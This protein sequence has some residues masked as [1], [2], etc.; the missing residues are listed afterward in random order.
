PALH[1]IFLETELANG[2]TDSGFYSRI[3]HGK[4]ASLDTEFGCNLDRGFGQSF[5]LREQFRTKQVDGEITITHV[6]PDGLSQ[7]AHGLQAVKGVALHAPATF[8]AE[9]AAENVGDGIQVGRDVQSP[10]LEIVAGI[11]DE[12]DV[13]GRD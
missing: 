10:P 1:K 2:R 13:L 4:D 11:H 6:K 3:A 7:L 5:S 8:F 12:C 9:Q